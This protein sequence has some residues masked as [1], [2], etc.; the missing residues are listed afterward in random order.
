MRILIA[1][2]HSD[3]LLMLKVAFEQAGWE[4]FTA[5]DGRDALMVYHNAI[6]K[7]QYF[8]ALLLDVKMPRLNGFAV[9]MNV[10]NLEAFAKIP[11]ACHVY[12][13]GYEDAVPPQELLESRWLDDV[14][15]DGYVHKPV[16]LDELIGKIEKLVNKE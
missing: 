8:D 12:L 10:R 3:S 13:T 5:V 11:R 9:G 2:D 14:F 4:V 15:V 7:D 16:N 1:E 6:Q